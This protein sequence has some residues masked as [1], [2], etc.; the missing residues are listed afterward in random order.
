[1]IHSAALRGEEKVIDLLINCLIIRRKTASRPMVPRQDA[2]Y[3]HARRRPRQ[4]RARFDFRWQDQFNLGLDPDTARLFH[5]ETLPK[6]A[7]KTAHFCSM[8]RPQF[9]SM[10]TT[11]GLRVEAAAMAEREK[12]WRKRALSLWRKVASFMCDGPRKP[13]SRGSFPAV[14]SVPK[15]FT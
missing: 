10:K 14:W 1:L 8:C 2:A 7:H 3:R 11:Q 12:A 6:E 9:C 15:C 4:G 5:D 13:T